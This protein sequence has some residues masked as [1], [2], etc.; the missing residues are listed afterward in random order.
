L[1]ELTD[2]EFGDYPNM[3]CAWFYR[4]ACT[5][6][7]AIPEYTFEVVSPAG[8]RGYFIGYGYLSGSDKTIVYKVKSDNTID[9]DWAD[10]GGWHYNPPDPHNGST[11]FCRDVYQMPDGRTLVLHDTFW[12]EG[13]GVGDGGKLVTCTMLDVDGVIDSSWGYQGHYVIRQSGAEYP[14]VNPVKFMR[15]NTGDFYICGSCNAGAPYSLHKFNS[16]GTRL[17]AKDYTEAGNKR[18]Q[19]IYDGVW[20]DDTQNRLIVVGTGQNSPLGS[21]FNCCAIDPDIG[22]V[23]VLW[24]GNIGEGGY[25]RIQAVVPVSTL[26]AI[27]IE[28]LNDGTFVIL[29]TPYGSDDRTMALLKAD[30]SGYVTSFGTNGHIEAGKPGSIYQGLSFDGTSIFTLARKRSGG[31]D[32]AK[33]QW[34]RNYDTSGNLIQSHDFDSPVAT[35]NYRHMSA[36]PQY[37]AF[38]TYDLEPAEYDV[39]WWGHDM[40]RKGGLE[41]PAGGS[42]ISMI[43]AIGSTY[44]IVDENPAYIIHDLVS[45]NRYGGRF[46]ASKLHITDLANYC[47]ENDLLISLALKERKPLEHWID[48]ILA[49]C[50][51]YRLWSGD[52]LKLGAFRDQDPVDPPIVQS[53]LHP[54]GPGPKVGV[55]VRDRSETFNRVEIGWSNRQNLY[56]YSS[57]PAQDQV[58]QRVSE[59]QGLPAVR[60]STNDLDGICR[61]ELAR[62]IAWQKLYEGMYRFKMFKFKVGYKHMLMEVGDVKLLSDGHKIVNQKIRILS[63]KEEQFGRV[64]SVEA[65]EDTSAMYPAIDYS[66]QEAWTPW[67]IFVGDTLVVSDA[68]SISVTPIKINEYDGVGVTDSATVSV[69]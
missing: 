43:R 40:T 29:Y 58:D 57:E 69:V 50:N 33:I 1:S 65:I 25:A 28:R 55:I 26:A 67:Q 39:E 37:F 17:Y 19:I 11:L 42:S 63:I 41:M 52:T 16:D 62:Q 20:S 47:D 8:P 5:I 3:C 59:A 22:D 45:S 24:T 53:D 15:D 38:A 54:K 2:E 46:D 32:D 9:T 49:H 4:K 66:S 12:I 36:L 60:I 31:V 51:G 27:E 68:G 56:D 30:G 6:D 64:L 34:W 7:G 44:D 10:G 21:V 48:H 18:P 23:D 14:F 61:I 35:D 13:T